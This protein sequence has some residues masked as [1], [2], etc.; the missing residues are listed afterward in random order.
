[1]ATDSQWYSYLEHG[2]VRECDVHDVVLDE[3][4]ECWQCAEGDME[5]EEDE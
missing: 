1:M 2:F 4:E 5:D 3:G